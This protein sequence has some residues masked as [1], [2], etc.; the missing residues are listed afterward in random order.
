MIR[1]AL[2]F[3][4]LAGPMGAIR[5]AAADEGMW[6]FERFPSAAI[7][8][9]YGVTIDSAWLDRIRQSVVRLQGCTGSFVSGDG[10]ILTNHHCVEGCLA[11]HSTREKSLI[12][13][14]VLADR[15]E[16]EIRCATQIADVLVGTE[17][18]T[19]RVAEA[20]HGLDDR[21]AKERRRQTLT[22]LEQA[23]EK[24]EPLQC[25]AETL[26]GGGQYWLYKY[27][28][29]AD[30]RL[31]FTPEDAIASFG[32]DPD[33]FQFPRWDLDMA[34]LRAYAGDRP[35]DTPN[36]FTIDFAGPKAGQPVFVAGHPGSTDREL[37]VAQLTTL[38]DLDLPQWLL[39]YSE[40][41]GRYIQFAKTSPSAA[42]IV[43]E[44]LFGL[45]NSIKVRRKLLD[46]LL[47]DD[48]M[49]R[50][51]DDEAALRR[52]V[53]ND[54]KLR[55]EIGDPWTRIEAAERAQAAIFLRH[56][57]LE[58]TAGFNSRLFR[59][60]R[61]LVRAATER[62]KPNA[63]R[64]REYRDSALPE[65]EQQIGA[66]APIY[67]EL[68]ELTLSFSLERMREWLGPDDPIVRKLL[69][70]ESPDSLA[71]SLV[72]G[73]KLG[74]PAER[75]RL[76][77]GGASAVDASRDPMIVLARDVDPEAR[78]LRKRQEDEVDAITEVAGEAIAKARFAAFGTNVYPDATFTLRLNPGTVQG[79]DENGTAVDP[80]TRLGRLFERATG[81][82]PFAVP[83]SW[84][85]VR[86]AL[87]PATPFNLSTNNDIVGGN[88]GSP[89]ID[90]NGRIVGLIFDGNIHSISGSYWF[91]T[92]KNRAV[93]VDMAAIREAL[94]KVYK[95]DRLAEEI[96]LS[97]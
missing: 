79:W 25:E 52:R 96:G 4:L 38:R 91:D 85:K 28:R 53:A 43:P 76:W 67:P 47:D 83:E 48:F 5:F 82:P 93:A 27:R 21:A 59:Y 89:L 70:T 8:K 46:T 15:R 29:Y 95:A 37:T 58:D 3:V 72:T 7:A 30:V 36:H 97:R 11:Q 6:T 68:E 39:R 20:V 88:S 71:A 60:A 12:E 42:R 54:P 44:R 63:E 94:S 33:N 45:E 23:C 80:F 57:Y 64:L 26:Y 35:A 77:R 17:D 34:L 16:D 1:N 51:R 56:T 81:Q 24:A 18:V 13:S 84:Q 10:L 32:G 50:K 74:D 49:R 31:A 78:A 2:L 61:E 9:T 40:L 86:S 22:N 87:D 73:S 41:R 62:P 92:A 69:A 90:A 65:L 19:A 66:A 14:G 55:A 75:L